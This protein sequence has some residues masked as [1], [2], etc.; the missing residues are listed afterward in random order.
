MA[1]IP[2]KN[3][4]LRRYVL[5][6]DLFKLVL[7]ALFLTVWYLGA[8]AYNQS[9]KKYPPERLM[10]GWKL[11]LW[12]AA[13]A[14]VGFFLFRIYTFFTDR[15]Y[16]AVI[17]A[18]GLSQSYEASRDPGLGNATDYDFRLNTS[19]RIK[20]SGRR[21]QSRIHFEQKPGFYFYYY[22]STEIVKLRGLPYP[23]AVS[24][25]HPN[26]KKRICAACGQIALDTESHCHVCGHSLIDPADLKHK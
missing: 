7:Y 17:T 1:K 6:K 19:L 13:A 4:D 20:K 2:C 18:S 16:R 9:H 14:L 24:G 12:M 5:G 25:Q 22:E 8:Y 3:K 15:S 21:K 23:I 26:A 11:L 10:L